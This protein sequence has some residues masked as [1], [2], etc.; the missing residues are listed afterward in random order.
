MPGNQQTSY[1]GTR[2]RFESKLPFR[3]VLNNLSS[4]VGRPP[5]SELANLSAI[6]STRAE[7]ASRIKE[8]IGDSEFMLFLEI[9]HGNW[10]E[11]FGIKRK[12]VRWI[13]GNP[14]IAITMIRH[15][16]TAG[17]F[18]PVE[19]LL[20]ENKSG[21]GSSITYDLPSS[22]IATEEN[23]DLM[24]AALALDVKYEK[25]IAEAVKLG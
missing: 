13:L 16:I 21:D 7:F 24:E 6:P 1:T 2:I 14:L 20:V 17:L 9:D 25:L 11:K 22:L 15:N 23:A 10:L 18:V 8:C 12:V 5:A 4:H 3:T 19:L